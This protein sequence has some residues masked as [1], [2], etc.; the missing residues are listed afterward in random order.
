VSEVRSRARLGSPSKDRDAGHQISRSLQQYL[1]LS[2]L[3]P[4]L[5]DARAYERL[6]VAWP[7]VV[8]EELAAHSSPVSL[9]EGGVLRVAVDH[10]GWA[11][12]LSFSASQV[13]GKLGGLL[14]PEGCPKRMIVSTRLGVT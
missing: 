10:Q 6:V 4:A 2:G 14:G 3:T 9:S 5:E 7:D 11:T 8:G 1:Q 13:L 12:E